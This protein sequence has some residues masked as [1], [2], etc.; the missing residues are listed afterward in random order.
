M[1]YI[2]Q[3]VPFISQQSQN[4]FQDI[5]CG[6]A[7]LMMMLKFHKLEM[8]LSFLELCNELKLNVDPIK[9]GY[10]NN[11]PLGCYPEDIHRFLF[12]RNYLYRTHFYKNE[13]YD[14]LEN[15]GPIMIMIAAG[16]ELGHEEGHWILLIGIEDEKFIYLDPWQCETENNFQMVI[17]QKQFFGNWTGIACQIAKM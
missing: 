17:D 6:A 13:F 12:N 5:G 16:T 1:K 10:P 3:N 2:C 4:Q 11:Q 8:G 7:C 15:S 9:K 14:A